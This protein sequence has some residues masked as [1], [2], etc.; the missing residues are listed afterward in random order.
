LSVVLKPLPMVH[1]G[2]LF[3]P[4]PRRLMQPNELQRAA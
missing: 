4:E 3:V 1:V 2:K